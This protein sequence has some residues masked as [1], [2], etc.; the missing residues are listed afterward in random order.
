MC[1]GWS[2]SEHPYRTG[3]A[4]KRISELIEEFLKK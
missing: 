1:M 2:N 4:T 3:D